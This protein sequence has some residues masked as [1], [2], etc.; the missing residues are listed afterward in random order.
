MTFH[1]HLIIILVV[2]LGTQLTRWLPF[3]VFPA[4][5]EAPPFIRYLGRVLPGAV[6]SLLIVY[7]LKNVSPLA[8]SRGLPELIAIAVTAALHL[9]KG[10]M[11]LSI[12]AGTILYMILIQNIFT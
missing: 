8:G 3:M 5:K 9:W 12:S 2:A 7:C 10:Q 4:G 6:F 1:E 11:L